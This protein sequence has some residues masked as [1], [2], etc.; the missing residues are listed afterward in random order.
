M[1]FNHFSQTTCRFHLI[2]SPLYHCR[3]FSDGASCLQTD[4]KLLKERYDELI[5]AIDMV[6]FTDDVSTLQYTF[7]SIDLSYIYKSYA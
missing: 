1:P 7:G 2:S 4:A 6:G 3:Y 5:N